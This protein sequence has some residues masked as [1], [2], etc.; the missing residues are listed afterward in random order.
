MAITSSLKLLPFLGV[1]N[2]TNRSNRF[3]LAAVVMCLLNGIV[4]TGAFFNVVS[5][6]GARISFV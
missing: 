1:A 3:G 6:S 5:H 2:H 4:V